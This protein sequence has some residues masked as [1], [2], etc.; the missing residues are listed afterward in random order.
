MI[1]ISNRKRFATILLPI[2][3]IFSLTA[4]GTVFADDGTG[5]EAAAGTAAESPSGS[6]MDSGD[7]NT[8]ALTDAADSTDNAQDEVAEDLGD[9]ST[10]T[11]EQPNDQIEDRG[12]L[13][14]RN[15]G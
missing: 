3:L 9:D 13:S 7:E 14:R 10:S 5:S 15:P 12:H 2:M 1:S 11:D 8:P 4:F 6:E